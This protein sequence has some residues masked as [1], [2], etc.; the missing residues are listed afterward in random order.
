MHTSFY[1]ES[2]PVLTIS[3]K[4]Y[5]DIEVQLFPDI[6]PNT[7]KNFISLVQE[8]YFTGSTF[9]RVISGFML[10]GGQ[11]K[12]E[13][14]PIRGEF[15]SNGHDNPLK[16]TKGV[17]SM[18]RTSFPNSGSSQFFLMHET[19]PH[20]DGEYASFGIATKGLELIDQI[21]NVD[22]NRQDVPLKPV[23]IEKITVDTKGFDYSNVVYT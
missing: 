1:K 19:S 4:D 6:A 11:G 15:T 5:G 2:N 9:H 3:I 13:A 17:I 18:A 8:E 7:V 20:L 16:H 23:V 12:T 21:A 22:T 14:K 10:Q